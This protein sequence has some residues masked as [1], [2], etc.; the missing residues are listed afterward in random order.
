MAFV[1]GDLIIN[2]HTVGARPRLVLSLTDNPDVIV[3]WDSD[4][5]RYKRVHAWAYDLLSPATDATRQEAVDHTLSEA[6]ARTT[7][8]PHW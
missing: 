8:Q 6:Y 3:V 2:K 1:S 5:Q 4:T 7:S